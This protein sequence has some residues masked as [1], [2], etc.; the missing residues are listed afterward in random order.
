MF[1]AATLGLL[2][3]LVLA[4]GVAAKGLVSGLLES[5]TTLVTD[6]TGAVTGTQPL[7]DTIT[8]I[9][10]RCRPATVWLL[11]DDLG[12]DSAEV[13]VELI[14]IDRL[15]TIRDVSIRT[16]Q[17]EALAA[18][19]IAMVKR[20]IPI[21]N[22]C[23]IPIEAT[24][25]SEPRHDDDRC[26][27]RCVTGLHLLDQRMHPGPDRSRATGVMRPLEQEKRV[28]TLSEEIE[29]PGSRNSRAVRPWPD[30]QIGSAIARTRTAIERE[31]V[32]EAQVSCLAAEKD[33]P[34]MI[35]VS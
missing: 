16:D 4:Q 5:T 35:L 28:L 33:R 7:T 19:P 6:T 9:S 26:D 12:L 22:H 20:A 18:C 1:T 13:G 3:S 10:L 21:A 24:R 2:A 17:V 30:R 29:Q 14:W 27:R 31:A 23:A 8:E 25:S 34:G 11:I 15:R 32:G